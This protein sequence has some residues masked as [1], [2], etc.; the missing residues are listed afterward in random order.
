MT[1]VLTSWKEIAQ[2]VGKAV[3]TAQRWEL[4]FG[5]PVRRPSI[6]NHQAVLA[7]P[8]EIDAWMRA[9]MSGSGAPSVRRFRQEVDSLREEVAGLRQ[10]LESLESRVAAA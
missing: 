3:R 6:G 9:R 7:I 1:S 10:R 8:E 4:D 5:L 2:Y